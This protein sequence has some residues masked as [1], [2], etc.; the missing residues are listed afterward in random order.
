MDTGLLVIRILSHT[1]A[2]TRLRKSELFGSDI[3]NI[4]GTISHEFGHAF[5]LT[6]L[7]M[8]CDQNPSRSGW[9]SVMNI[10]ECSGW[11]LYPSKEDVD[12]VRA[13]MDRTIDPAR[14]CQTSSGGLCFS[15]PRQASGND[16]DDT[17]IAIDNY[18][19]IPSPP[20]LAGEEVTVRYKVKNRGNVPP[21]S[22]RVAVAA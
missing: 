18:E 14:E 6:D 3:V 20:V 4:F 15:P 12:T 1:K 7:P 22:G 8:T 10:R 13:I 5:G 11:E 17:D 19:V 2:I 21:R 16:N 9:K